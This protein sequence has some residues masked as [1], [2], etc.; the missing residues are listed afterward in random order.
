MRILCFEAF[1]HLYTQNGQWILDIQ[2]RILSLE[3]EIP[4]SSIASDINTSIPAA[5][6][7]AEVSIIKKKIKILERHKNKITNSLDWKH[8]WIK[9]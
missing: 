8:Q 5:L 7:L 3:K 4:Q 1:T 6:Y 9:F 2:M